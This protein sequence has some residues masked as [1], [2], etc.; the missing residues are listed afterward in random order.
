MVVSIKGNKIS[1]Q[2]QVASQYE[3]K[4]NH[5]GTVTLSYTGIIP[6]SLCEPD[7]Y[8]VSDSVV[9]K[10]IETLRKS[11]TSFPANFLKLPFGK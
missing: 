11:K 2:L 10:Q 6:V 7:S 1:C 8:R 5:A 9:K 3:I 4:L